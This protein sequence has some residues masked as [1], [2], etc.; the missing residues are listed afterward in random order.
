MHPTEHVLIA[1]LTTSPG[2]SCLLKVWFRYE[3]D[4]PLAVRFDF[5]FF[6]REGRAGTWVFARSLLAEGLVEPTGH[7]DVRVRPCGEGW[8]EVMLR[9]RAADAAIRFR[10]SALRQ[11]LNVTEPWPLDTD[12]QIDECLEQLLLE[13]LPHT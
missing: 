3:P 5:G 4:D 6:G 1:S 9:S 11:F 13:I 12:G 2:A 8:V 7:G 10:T